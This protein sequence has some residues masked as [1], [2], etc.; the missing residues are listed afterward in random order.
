MPDVA[1]GSTSGAV[2]SG[3]SGDRGYRLDRNGAH[4]AKGVIGDLQSTNYAGGSRGWRLGADGSGEM[5]DITVNLARVR[6]TISAEHVS[7]DVRNWVPM[8]TASATINITTTGDGPSF[9]LLRSASGFSSIFFIGTLRGSSLST[10]VPIGSIS[11]FASIFGWEG[12]VAQL[13]NRTRTLSVTLRVRID[14]S[15]LH[16]YGVANR[17]SGTAVISEVW[18]VALPTAT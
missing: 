7:S 6:G 18:G 2:S 8:R 16:T 11:S 4:F 12:G 17:A 10:F 5:N 9:N 14:G 1:S 3:L 15:T 13:L